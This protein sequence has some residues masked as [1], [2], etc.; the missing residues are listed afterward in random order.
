M[1]SSRLT[2]MLLVGLIFALPAAAADVTVATFVTRLAQSKNVDAADARAAVSALRD[3]G[4]QLPSD[5]VLTAPLTEGDV[6]RIS[7]ALGL[8]VSTH[9]PTAAFSAEQIDSFFASPRVE[10]ALATDGTATIN[11]ARE[12]PHAT[13]LRLK[14]GRRDGGKGKKRGREDSPEEPE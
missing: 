11:G 3:V 10:L 14:L 4:V 8:T 12:N 13:S 2:A 7:R 6:A 1:I 9:R 5:L